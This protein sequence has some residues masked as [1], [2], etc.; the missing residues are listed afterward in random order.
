M[1]RPVVRT[2]IVSRRQ[3]LGG[4]AAFLGAHLLPGCDRL[5]LRQGDAPTSIDPL[6]S[7]AN[8]YITS[9]AGSPSL[10]RSD[11]SLVIEDGGTIATFDA[12]FLDSVAAR[13]TERTLQ[14]IGSSPSNQAI[15]NAVWEGLPL[16]ELLEKKDI[17]LRNSLEIVMHGGDGYA[18]ALPRADVDRPMWLVWKM[19]GEDLPRD[20]GF[21]A[22]LLSPGRYGT[23]NV[24]W[25]QKISLVDE[26]FV[27]FW[28]SRGWSDDATYRA[29]TFVVS[30]SSRTVVGTESV[31]L[32]TAFEGEDP[33]VRVEVSTD[34]G[35]SWED[36]EIT[37][38]PGAGIWVLWRKDWDAQP[39]DYVVSARC[40]TASGAV[41]NP[42]PNGTDP[43][44]GYDGS[45]AIEVTVA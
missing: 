19:N 35:G 12:A 27:G 29:N 33:V 3:L 31:I 24:K 9:S 13:E 4:G 16:P 41:S 42:D 5:V 8:F 43:G 2:Q 37:Y 21:P 15:S 36:A 38:G 17:T 6:T 14:C 32:V 25:L 40:T 22:R 10:Q 28:E 30:P 7:N 1:S 23:K 39:G 18:T 45:M 20:H 11:W 26:P 44:G 34:D